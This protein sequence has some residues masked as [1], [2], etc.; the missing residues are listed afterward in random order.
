MLRSMVK[1]VAGSDR[2]SKVLKPGV[3][4]ISFALGAVAGFSFRSQPPYRNRPRP[5]EPDLPS[6]GVNTKAFQTEGW[7]AIE[8]E[9]RAQSAL[10][11]ALSASTMIL[12]VVGVIFAAFI[13]KDATEKGAVFVHDSGYNWVAAVYELVRTAAVAALIAAAIWGL[14]N[15]SRAAIDQATR[16]RK[17][18]TAGSFLVFMLSNYN[19]E[20]RSGT[21]KL[22][23]VMAV[24]TTWS[25]SVESAYT[26]V[27]FGSKN[28]QRLALEMG[29]DSASLVSGEPT[30]NDSRKAGA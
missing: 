24:F 9:L 7:K 19:D 26:T 29:R 5:S 30:K 3:V 28:N 6:A 8:T 23:S 27:K 2:D 25:S 13:G 21:L 17:R 15:M 18:L 10:S 4:A 14:L 11:T 1:Y 16:Y 12:G 22:E 20:L